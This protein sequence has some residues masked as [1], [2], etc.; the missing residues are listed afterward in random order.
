MQGWIFCVFIGRAFPVELLIVS[1]QQ[2]FFSTIYTTTLFVSCDNTSRF[3]CSAPTMIV[4]G[5]EDDRTS[6]FGSSHMRYFFITHLF[7]PCRVLIPNPLPP[8]RGI[9]TAGPRDNT[10]L[11][12]VVKSTCFSFK[13]VA[14]TK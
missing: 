7:V 12:R 2:L 3:S 6:C 8:H 13:R 4:G 10:V 5:T 14:Q 9:A 11:T 1:V